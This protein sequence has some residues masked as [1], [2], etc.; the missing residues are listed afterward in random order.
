MYK[1]LTFRSNWLPG[2]GFH[3]T[4][5]N[6]IQSNQWR[7][8]LLSPILTRLSAASTRIDCKLKEELW[9]HKSKKNLKSNDKD[10]TRDQAVLMRVP[11]TAWARVGAL[12]ALSRSWPRRAWSTA[13]ECEYDPSRKYKYRNMRLFICTYLPTHVYVCVFMFVRVRKI[14]LHQ[15]EH[16]NMETVLPSRSLVGWLLIISYTR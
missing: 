8:L 14:I 4:K 11:G 15:N 12:G 1:R 3:T 9:V 2:G 7:F 10:S 13:A 5:A 6:L 16:T